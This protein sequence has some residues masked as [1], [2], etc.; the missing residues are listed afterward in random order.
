MLLNI[1]ALGIV[2]ANGLWGGVAEASHYRYGHTSWRPTGVTNQIDFT[3]QN[4]FRRDANPCV[5]VTTNTTVP[6]T[7]GGDPLVGDVI[8]EFTGGTTFDFGDL[9]T[10]AGSPLGPLYYVVTSIDPV[11]NWLLGIALDENSLPAIDTAITHTYAAT[12]DYL[13]FTDSVARIS[14]GFAPNDHMNN[15]DGGYRIETLVNV[16]TQGA[17]SSPV[18]T[19][20][21]IV[22]CP[23]NG[24]CSFQI[25]TADPNGDPLNFR[26]STAAE[27]SSFTPF[28]N[29]V[30]NQCTTTFCQPGPPFSTFAASVSPTGLYTWD[31]TGADLSPSSGFNTLYSSQ[32]TIEDLNAAGAVKSKVAVDWLIQLVTSIGNPPVFDHPPTPTCGTTY[33]INVGQLL[34]FTV[35]ASD[36]DMGDVVTLNVVGLP[37]GATMTPPLPAMGNPV[38][39]VFS[40]T[41]AIGPATF[42]VTFTAT[43][44]T[45][46]FATCSFVINVGPPLPPPVLKGRMTGGGGLSLADGTRVRHG[47]ALECDP[48]KAPHNLQVIWGTSG[49]PAKKFHL[50]MLTMAPRCTL[51]PSISA[52]NP[53]AGFNTYEGEGIGRF[54]GQPGATARWKF[55]DQSEPGRNDTMEITIQNGM[56]TVLTVPPGSKLTSGNHQAH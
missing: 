10:P 11:N 4:A 24:L 33:N 16:G 5:D 40:F 18:T 19:L 44:Q 53:A 34:T 3:V 51:D 46:Q 8:V 17:N 48:L 36:P 31:T 15:P 9:S 47:F 21:V 23:I 30:G 50:E 13:A 14:A 37:P 6:C 54:N 26:L 43:D 42:V 29:S 55:T 12:G 52:G 41:P 35:Q 27:A 22:P 7:G 38:S 25:P 56:T 32:V 20:P 28:A 49:S 1:M 45:L 2:A 39:S